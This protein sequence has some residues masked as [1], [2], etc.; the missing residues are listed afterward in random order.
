MKNKLL[1]FLS[2]FLVAIIIM[3]LILGSFKQK[4]NNINNNSTTEQ[5]QSP[6][7]FYDW[8]TNLHIK[9]MEIFNNKYSDDYQFNYDNTGKF[10][11]TLKDLED[12]G[13]DL[14][15]FDNDTVICDKEKSFFEVYFEN[16]EQL[17]SVKLI[18]K[19]K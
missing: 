18:C 6:E 7:E 17:R 15:D 16:E 11:L 10:I 3:L 14:S 4:K 12:T 19:K 5:N 8:E 9:A 1:I 13:V 2:F